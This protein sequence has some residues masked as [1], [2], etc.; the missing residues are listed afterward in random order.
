MN[1]LELINNFVKDITGIDFIKEPLSCDFE[2]I[3]ELKE[4]HEAIID[5][6]KS[7]RKPYLNE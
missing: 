5:I 6:I 4:T 7:K 3:P 1:I 2:K